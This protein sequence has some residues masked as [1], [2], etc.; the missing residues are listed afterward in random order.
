VLYAFHNPGS[1]EPAILLGFADYGNIS[2]PD[3]GDFYAVRYTKSGYVFTVDRAAAGLGTGEYNIVP[4]AHSTA[5]GGWFALF[6]DKGVPKEPCSSRGQ[7]AS[8]DSAQN[9][10]TNRRDE[11]RQRT[12]IRPM[13]PIRLEHVK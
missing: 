10:R 3:V 7:S 9:H 6:F 5:T 8:A 4:I 2:R 12:A 13:R 11:Q 1:G